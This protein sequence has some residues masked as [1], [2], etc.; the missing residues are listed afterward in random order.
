MKKSGGA[1]EHRQLL[2]GWAK[3]YPGRTYP[4]IAAGRQSRR[5]QPYRAV[6]LGSAIRMGQ[7]LPDALKFIQANQSVL[8]K[9]PFGT[10]VA[11]MTLQEDTEAKRQEASAYLDPVRALGKTGQR[12]VVCRSV[13]PCQDG[14]GRSPD[15]EKP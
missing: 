4:S 13:E 8:Q 12:G 14:V 2:P 5:P 11:C 7:I 9:K 1:K 6:I 3:S 10:F 15:H